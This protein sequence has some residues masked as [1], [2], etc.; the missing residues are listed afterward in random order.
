MTD[1]A[2][3]ISMVQTGGFIGLLIILAFPTLRAKF[4]FG[5]ER[6]NVDELVNKIM[7]ELA[8][9][10]HSPILVK[11]RIIRICDDVATLKADVSIIKQ[12]ITRKEV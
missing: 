6:I 5:G 1:L 8:E 9:N 12:V 7:N 3:L 11:N 10:D 4:G 2:P